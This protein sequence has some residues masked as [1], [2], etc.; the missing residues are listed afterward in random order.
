M[1]KK[2]SS[3]GRKPVQDQERKILVGFYI[4]Q[5]FVDRVG[6]LPEARRIAAHQLETYDTH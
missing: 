4:Q 2:K 1:T 6:G 5:K 3:A